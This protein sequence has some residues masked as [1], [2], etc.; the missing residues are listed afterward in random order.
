M[1]TADGLRVKV[2]APTEPADHAQALTALSE[3]IP[4]A[5]LHRLED[6][7]VECDIAVIFGVGKRRVPA[8]HARGVIVYEH[9]FRERKPIIIVERGFVKRDDYYGVALDGLNGLGYFGEKGCPSDRWD[10]LDTP[11]RPWQTG[12][13]IL[14]CGQVPWDASVQHTNHVEWCQSTCEKIKG[15]TDRP[16]RF[17][18]HPQVADFDYGIEAST[19]P[20]EDDL[21]DAHCIVTFS[22]TSGALAVLDGIPL[23]ATDPGSIAWPVANQTI[24]AELLEK[25]EL[26]D[27]DQ[28]ACDL[29]YSQWTYDEMREGLPW[30]RLWGEEKKNRP[31]KAG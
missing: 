9:R 1:S 18:P 21:K 25:P 26:K 3:G 24:T 2:F 7:Y 20:L 14:V 27:R 29:A 13:H 12:E 15:L 16:V 4:G 23:F 30:V 19:G 8:S 10:A 6:G 28:W 17:R 31:N 11:I 22:S 5:E